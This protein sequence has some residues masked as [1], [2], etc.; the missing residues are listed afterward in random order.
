ML[1]MSRMGA[2]AA[3]LHTLVEVCFGSFWQI[4]HQELN[5]LHRDSMIINDRLLY[6]TQYRCIQ[7]VYTQWGCILCGWEETTSYKAIYFDCS[8]GINKYFLTGHTV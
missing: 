4:K 2:V 6:Y 1:G 3:N 8:Y 5:P 7:R